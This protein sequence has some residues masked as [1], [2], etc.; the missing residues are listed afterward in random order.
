MV[1]VVTPSFRQL[2]WLCLCVASV[3]DQHGVEV[4]HIVQDGGTEGISLEKLNP[5]PGD[6]DHRLQL[7]VEKDGGMYD[8]INRGLQRAT[9]EICAYLNCD[10]QYL[11]EALAKVERFFRAHPQIDVLFGDIILIDENGHPLSYRRSILPSANHIR[12]SHL[13]TASCAMFFRRQLIE[14]G[15]LFDTQWKTIGD[16]AWV[17]SL[18]EHHVPMAVLNEP[19]AVFTFTGENLGDTAVSRAEVARLGKDARFRRVQRV[20]AVLTHRTQKLFAGAYRQRSVA[21]SIYTRESPR[22]RVARS[23]ARLGYRWPKTTGPVHTPESS[24][25]RNSPT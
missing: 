9:G 21:F 8:A 16:A 13:N 22:Q 15:F 6:S 24:A 7:H 17:K 3:A 2:E 20:G 12:F 11:P 4:E 10:E 25:A 19:L 23:H 14:R 1:S 18:L 5:A